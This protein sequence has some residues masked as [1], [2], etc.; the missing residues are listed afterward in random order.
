MGTENETVTPM[1]ESGLESRAFLTFH[2][3]CDTGT[4]WPENQVPVSPE[5]SCR[6]EELFWDP[7]WLMLVVCV[8]G[9]CVGV[10][11]CV[12]GVH[13]F[14]ARV[15]MSESLCVCLWCVCLSL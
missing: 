4:S 5:L 15:F 3:C 10:C 11:A 12:H 1:A 14:A 7:G 13:V 9:V 2:S 6:Y 8:C